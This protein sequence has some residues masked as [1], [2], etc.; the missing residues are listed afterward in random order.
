MYRL[1]PARCPLHL[2][3]F[4]FVPVH[5]GPLVPGTKVKVKVSYHSRF[6]MPSDRSIP[7]LSYKQGELVGTIYTFDADNLVSI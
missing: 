7:R 5:P 4:E 1:I 6:A 2:S 3:S